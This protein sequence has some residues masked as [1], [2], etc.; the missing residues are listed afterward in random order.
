VFK[1]NALWFNPWGVQYTK[2]THVLANSGFQLKISGLQIVKYRDNSNVP[3]VWTT[4]TFIIM[5]R[6]IHPHSRVTLLYT[7][8]VQ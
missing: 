4:V 6:T 7:A 3:T 1:D 8:R 2:Y 5:R